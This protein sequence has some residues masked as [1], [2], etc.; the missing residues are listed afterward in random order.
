LALGRAEGNSCYGFSQKD[1]AL[2]A[3]E[4]YVKEPEKG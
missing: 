3:L 1:A 4:R 2:R